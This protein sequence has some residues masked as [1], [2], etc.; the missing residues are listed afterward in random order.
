M[1]QQN[2]EHILPAVIDPHPATAYAPPLLVD[3]EPEQPSLPASHYLW[4][5]RRHRWKILAFVAACTVAALIVSKRITPVYESTATVDVDRQTPTGVIGEEAARLSTNDT[6]QFLS[7]QIKLIQ[8]DSVLRPV[9]EKYKLRDIGEDVAGTP[10]LRSAAAVDAPVM[11]KKLKVTRPQNTYLLQVSYRS[12]DP[13]LA[14]NV[15]NGVAQSYLE[16]T[17]DI[18]YRSSV[19]LSSFMEKQIDELKAKM[20]RSSAALAR[21]EQELNVINPEEKTSILSARLLQLNSEYTTA[22]SDRV[23]REAAYESVK[24]GTLEA[25]QVSSQG[26]AV[27][28]LSDRLNDAETRFAEVKVH[29]GANHPEYRRAASQVAE[30]ERQLESTRQNIRQRVEIEYRE[31]MRRE[32]MLKRELAG[33][34]AEFDRVNSRSFEY[35]ALKREADADKSL[36]EEL[37]RKIKEAGINAGFQNS[38]IRVADPARPALDPVFPNVKLNVILAFLFSSILAVGAAV[39]SDVLDDTIRD[40]EQ[41][42]RVLRTEVIGTLPSVKN[43]RGRLGTISAAANNTS[44]ALVVA[45]TRD[46]ALTGY[47]EAVRTLRNSILLTDFDRRLRTILVTS[48][49]PAEGKSTVAAHL[50][51]AHAEQGHKTLLIDGDLRRPS[52]H[53]RFGIPSVLG[54]SNV[55]V[56]ELPWRDAL[57]KPQGVAELDILPAGPPSRRA[58][59]LVGRGLAQ[60]L[61]EAS[62]QYDLVILDAPPLLGFAEPLQ[63]A[64]SV[65]GVIVVTRA[66]ETSRKAINSVITTL[67]RLRANILGVVLNEVHQGMSSSYYYYGHYGNYYKAS[68]QS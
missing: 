67:S 53:R 43:W 23:R 21:F 15:A 31:A 38:T 64:T 63:M 65:D 6:E 32:N 3:S 48:A 46:Q 36:Y 30:V 61:E 24:G 7:T 54:L 13:R 49:S 4:I 41:V 10:R 34:K 47:D 26:E 17:F 52:V 62:S 55:L 5:L 2:T 42:T 22:Q 11:L 28:K 35:Q 56:A 29:Y 44:R 9:V 14:A 60:V 51:V 18:R 45:D 1:P 12:T 59:D 57:V 20:E 66:G 68:E 8:S 33:T 40:P 39:V 37:V 27:R 16:H 58:S 19:A 25:A 50:A